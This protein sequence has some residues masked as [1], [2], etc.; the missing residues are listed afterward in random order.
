LGKHV[1]CPVAKYPSH[2]VMYGVSAEHSGAKK[3]R[4]KENIWAYFTF[5]E[6]SAMVVP[7]SKPAGTWIS[8]NLLGI[9]FIHPVKCG[10]VES[11]IL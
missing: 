9:F 7:F 8:R 2:F 5:T 1:I 10:L 6:T 3:F 4:L 11:L